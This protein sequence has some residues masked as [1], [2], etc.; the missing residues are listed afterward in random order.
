[1][2][3]DGGPGLLV[4]TDPRPEDLDPVQVVAAVRGVFERLATGAAAQPPPAVAPFPG[5][6]DM[7]TYS[8]VDE[9]AGVVGVEVS[10]YLPSASGAVVTA[11][12]LLLSS[13]TG[14]PVA[15]WTR[16]R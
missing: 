13:R 15:C 5:G 7:I 8:G 6:G 1:M 2:T 4:V 10:P 9:Q 11:W 14:Q 16:W 12:T 3:G